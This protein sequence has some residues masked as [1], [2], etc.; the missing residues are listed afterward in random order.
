MG[1]MI[2]RASQQIEGGLPSAV[3]LKMIFNIIL[4]FGI[5]LVP[6]IGDLADVV[7]HANINA[8]EPEKYLREKGAKNLKAQGRVPPNPGPM[9]GINLSYVNTQNRHSDMLFNRC[10]TQ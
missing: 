1:L 2:P 10:S 6:F 3:K 7:F 8:I 9:E 4:D 5:G